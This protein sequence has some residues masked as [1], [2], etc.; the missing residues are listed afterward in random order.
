MTGVVPLPH[1]S[2]V[3]ARCTMKGLRMKPI[4]TP[5]CGAIAPAMAVAVARSEGE[6]H[7]SERRGAAP[8]IKALDMAAIVWPNN[9]TQ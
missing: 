3:S 7:V 2:T 8:H 6:N 4:K 5:H 9:S 1:R